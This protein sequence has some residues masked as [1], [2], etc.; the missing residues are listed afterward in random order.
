LIRTLTALSDPLYRAAFVATAAK[1]GV[2][3]RLADGPVQA[4]GLLPAGAT[5]ASRGAFTAWLDVGVG[6]GELKKSSKGYAL[7]GALSKALADPANDAVAALLEE[8]VGL[9]MDLL[10]RTPS[11][12]RAGKRFTL[13]DQDG[14]LI[15][16]SSRVLE[17]FV[18]EAVD[19]VIPTTGPVRLLEIG[20]GSGTY[21]RHAAERNSALTAVGLELQSEVAAAAR[22]NLAVWKLSSRVKVWAGDVREF[23]E[24]GFDVATMHNNIYYFPVE[25]RVA[26]LKHV[27]GLLRPGGRILLTTGCRGGTAAMEVLSLWGAATQG[28]GPLPPPAELTSQLESAGFTPARA[29]RLIPVESY[30]AFTGER[31]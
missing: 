19:S 26:L 3:G 13:A 30:Y 21:I 17:P 18:R 23:A 1:E 20:C 15:A 25:T 6:L 7:K 5:E 27:R 29:K 24:G 9:H 8:A 16:R 2:L 14:T 10:R 22:D 4:D 28:C 12:A 11:L 31:T